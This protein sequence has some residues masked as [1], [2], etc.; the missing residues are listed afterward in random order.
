[1]KILL[2]VILIDFA[3]IKSVSREEPSSNMKII[4]KV[5]L[6]TLATIISVS[7]EGCFKT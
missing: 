6:K 5:I 3:T 7:S 1:M 4:F 2:K